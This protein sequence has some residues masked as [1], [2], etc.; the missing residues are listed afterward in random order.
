M[1]QPPTFVP[2]TSEWTC[3]DKRKLP[4]AELWWPACLQLENGWTSLICSSILPVENVRKRLGFQIGQFPPTVQKL[5]FSHVFSLVFSHGFSHGFSGCHVWL[6]SLQVQ[7]AVQLEVKLGSL[8]DEWRRVDGAGRGG[9]GATSGASEVR[10]AGIIQLMNQFWLYDVV[11]AFQIQSHCELTRK[12]LW[13]LTPVPDRR[14]NHWAW[15]VPRRYHACCQLLTDFYYS[16]LCLGLPEESPG[17]LGSTSEDGASSAKS[18]L[19]NHKT[20]PKWSFSSYLMLFIAYLWLFM[21]PPTLEYRTFAKIE[22]DLPPHFT[23]I[24]APYFFQDKDAISSLKVSVSLSGAWAPTQGGRLC[25][26]GRAIRWVFSGPPGAPLGLSLRS[27]K[28]LQMPRTRKRPMERASLRGQLKGLVLMSS[29][30]SV[31]VFKQN[32]LVRRTWFLR[33]SRGTSVSQPFWSFLM[34]QRVQRSKTVLMTLRHRWPER[35]Q[36]EKGSKGRGGE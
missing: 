8:R 19:G 22:F 14:K 29:S 6:R 35:R 10:N 27:R 33:R 15:P 13:L 36:K 23:L 12:P 24:Q 20:A 31:E 21:Y 2:F 18:C 30:F 32:V 3:Q 34:V 26:T 11:C 25:A 9:L 28:K 17:H 4:D 16:A 7:H 1:T 5:R